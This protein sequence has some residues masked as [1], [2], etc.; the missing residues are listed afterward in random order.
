MRP[1]AAKTRRWYPVDSASASVYAVVRFAGLGSGG[2]AQPQ[3]AHEDVD[4]SDDRLVAGV[5]LGDR[6]AF[7]VLWDR[8]HLRVYGYCYRYLAKREPAEDATA[9][10]FR[11]ALASLNRYY[12]GRFRAWLF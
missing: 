7:G 11:R 8:Y 2:M 4:A 3:A 12:G 10:T 5:R 6:D 9:E 1:C